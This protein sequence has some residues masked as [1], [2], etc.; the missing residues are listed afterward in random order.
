MISFDNV[1]KVYRT[2]QGEKA[3]LRNVTCAFP[4]GRNVGI[5][6]PNGAGKSTLLRLIS[7]SEGQDRG[8]ISRAGRISFPL[9]FT[10]TFHPNLS[11]RQN[12]KFVARI[13]GEGVERVVAFVEDFSELGAYLDMP[14][15]TYSAGMSAKLAF[16]VSLAIDFDVYLIDE[17]TEVGDARFRKKCAQVFAERMAWSDIIMVSHNSATVKAYCDMGAIL[18]AGRIE[19][20]DSI[21]RAMSQYRQIMGVQ[22]A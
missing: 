7:G 4:Q 5:L 9:G 8:R 3:V 2:H 20:F 12:A 17:V 16:A 11:G 18:N 13:Y 6:G 10:G 15:M 19:F 21:D 1:T 22:D 14:I